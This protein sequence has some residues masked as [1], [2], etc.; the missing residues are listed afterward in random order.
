MP[1]SVIRR[2]DS[3]D[4]RR[5]QQEI[6][7][8][9]WRVF[10]VGAFWER[11]ETTT[12]LNRDQLLFDAKW[13]RGVHSP[14]TITHKKSMARRRYSFGIS[15]FYILVAFYYFF[16]E[17][18]IVMA[19]TL[20]VTRMTTTLVVGATGGT[21]RFVVQFL[22]NHQS[23]DTIQHVKV[24][25]RDGKKMKS[26]LPPQDEEDGKKNEDG[27]YYYGRNRLTIIEEGS[28]LTLSDERWRDMT[29]D[30][31][32]VVSC[33]GHEMTLEGMWGKRDQS[34]VS[35]T[36]ERLTSALSFWSSTELE[37][38]QEEEGQD[39]SKMMKQQ[40]QQQPKRRFLLM[41]SEGCSA[42]GDDR[43]SFRDRVLLQI[44]RWLLPPHVDNEKACEHLWSSLL[45]S[46]T[47]STTSS[48]F[49]EWVIVRPCDLIDIPVPDSKEAGQEGQEQPQPQP[50]QDEKEKKK[51]MLYTIYPKPTGTLFGS[52]TVSRMGVG[53]F[54]TDLI[55]DP[56][57]WATY[58]YHAPV[59]HGNSQD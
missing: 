25:C 18:R 32:N 15:S 3:L 9:G 57:I 5:C 34:L 46:S 21:G 6:L 19:S 16:F 35:H 24:L 2:I 44:F 17:I 1:Q 28:F 38:Q 56:Q 59:I 41:A 10:V 47:T 12:R 14:C 55:I 42:P 37:Q 13:E 53:R 43:R 23:P 4:H 33:L 52:G 49:P 31:S 30:C 36:V 58:K 48:T 39:T 26:L 11:H 51:S 50:L 27:S 29:K 7:H 40:Q 54:L 8:S 20:L 45:G 22:L